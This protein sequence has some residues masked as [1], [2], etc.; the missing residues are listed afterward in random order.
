MI[1]CWRL[2][3]KEVI[4]RRM[5]KFACV[6]SMCFS[7]WSSHRINRRR[8][9]LWWQLFNSALC[10]LSSIHILL[11][12]FLA[13]VFARIYQIQDQC[14]SPSYGTRW[15]TESPSSGELVI[16]RTQISSIWWPSLV[17]EFWHSDHHHITWMLILLASPKD[18][19]C[20]PV[21]IILTLMQT[22]KLCTNRMR[23]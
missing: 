18:S 16:L 10:S 20:L 11:L 23:I 2:S 19:S 1:C 17:I 13:S 15:T 5:K 12:R 7:D 4:A 14:L 3:P 8:T 22:I 21:K 9:G 6:P